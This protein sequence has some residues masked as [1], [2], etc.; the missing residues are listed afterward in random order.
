[1]LDPTRKRLNG[2]KY[3]FYGECSTACPKG[4]L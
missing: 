2:T 4:A 1:M 3:I